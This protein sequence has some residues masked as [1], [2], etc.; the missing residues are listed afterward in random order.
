M[1]SEQERSLLPKDPVTW[2]RECYE[3][4]NEAFERAHGRQPTSMLELS[5][6]LSPAPN[7][8]PWS[9]ELDSN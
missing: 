1:T 9:A 2:W 7:R 6:W 5:R 4:D 8:L 3:R